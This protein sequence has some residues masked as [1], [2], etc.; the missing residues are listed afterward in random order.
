M[1]KKYDRGEGFGNHEIISDNT[2]CCAE[3]GR[4][5]AVFYS[6]DDLNDVIKSSEGDKKDSV[7]II[8]MMGMPNDECWQGHILGL[9]SDG[10]VYIDDH[11][12]GVDEWVVYAPLNFK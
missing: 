3:S 6:D 12:N 9:G 10:I 5:V 4:V 1:G 7:K 2:L 8:Q 11:T